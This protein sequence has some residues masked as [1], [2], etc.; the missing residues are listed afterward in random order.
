MVL[1]VLLTATFMTTIDNT[2]VNVAVPSI[3]SDLQATGGEIQLVVASY[4]ITYAV[5]L[6]TGA[7][8][9]DLQGYRRLFLVG[10]AIFILASLACGLAPDVRLLIL[11]RAAQGAGAAMLAPQVLSGIQ[12]EFD[13]QAKAR[14]IGY[15]SVAIAGGAVA[16]QVLGGALVGADLF[17]AG[18]RSIFLVNVP[19]G[20]FGLLAALRYLPRWEGSADGRLD[21]AGVGAFSLAILL[22]LVPLTLGREAGWPLWA[23]I[24]LALSGPA[25]WL[26]VDVERRVD[27][28]GGYPLLDLELL[29]R[30]VIAF[31]L[32]AQSALT[33][34]ASG[35]LFVLAIY[36]QDG[37]GRSALYSGLMLAPWIVAFGVASRFHRSLPPRTRR[38]ASPL[39][40]VALAAAFLVLAAS[41]VV[42]PPDG[43]FL[44]AVLGVGGIGTGLGFTGIV[45]HLTSRVGPGH[46]ADLSGLIGTNSEVFGAVGVA[47]FGSLFLALAP[48]P[49]GEAGQLALLVVLVGLGLAALAA[50]ASAYRS[51]VAQD[52]PRL[53]SP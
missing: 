34:T 46:A 7:R 43:P 27:A 32:L 15:Y 2:I 39:G 4:F 26:F 52:E 5:L 37:L 9:G 14:A 21:L 19:L 51:I 10:L 50:A 48:R 1:A 18:W 25:L 23:F 12:L 6:I 29:R 16:G 22:F 47:T 53:I 13:G 11:A 40:F 20:L 45:D 36:L 42:R 49:S 24:G 30:P 3:R 41:S 31:G 38:L 8:L 33:V 17:G 44:A 28:R 35:L